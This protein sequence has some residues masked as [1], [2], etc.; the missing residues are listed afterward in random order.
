MFS[1]SHLHSIFSDGSETPAQLVANVKAAGYRA[2]IL[3][4]HDTMRGTHLLQKEARRAGL[5]SLV[6]CE[7]TTN[8][9]GECI[10]VLA[11]DFDTENKAM[12]E[13]MKR[14]SQRQTKRSELLFRAGLECGTL[15]GGTSW[16]EVAAAFPDNDFLCNTQV[17]DVLLKKGIYRPEERREY[18]KNNFGYDLPLSRELDKSLPPLADIEE[19]IVTIRRAGGVPMIA[20]PHGFEKYADDIVRMGVMGFETH[21][22]ELDGEDISFFTSLCEENRL[23][24]SGGTDHE[25]VYPISEAVGYVNEENF[26]KL[27]RR[28]LG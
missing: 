25:H 6:G 18:W 11:I 12:R 19:A 4:D 5:L 3:T 14:G 8:G 16:E 23:Y 7:I 15:R 21:H 17:F 22:P 1:N 27:Y 9:F 13:L 26:M 10:H 24:Q 2:L 28:E 20:H